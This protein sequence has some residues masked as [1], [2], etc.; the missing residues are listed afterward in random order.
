MSSLLCFAAGLTIAVGMSRAAD[1]VTLQDALARAYDTNPTLQ[2]ARA[3]LRATD[4]QIAQAKS[5]RRPTVDVTGEVGGQVYDSDTQGDGSSVP[6]TVALNLTQPIYRGGSIDAS[7]SQAD[8]VI[9]AQRATLISVEQQVLLRAV[10]AYMD[11]VRDQA[12]LELT[13]NNEEVLTRQLEAT[14]VRFEVGELTRTDV[15]QAESRLAGATAQRIQAEGGLTTSVAV[16]REVIGEDPVDLQPA[17]P[18]A[19]LPGDETETVAASSANPD[20]V[21]AQFLER[22]ARDGTDVV[23]GE[24]LPRV[25]VVGR[26]QAE[27]DISRDGQYD[28]SAQA[29]LQVRIPLYQAG[30]VDS[31]VREA[32]QRVSQR[33]Q[34]VQ[35]QERA[36]TQ[37]ATSAWR[38]L[39]TARAQ[40][41]SFESQVK[42]TEIALQ[43]VREE[44]QVGARTVLDTLDA[45]QEFLDARVSLVR[46]RRDEVVAAHQVLAAVGQLTAANLNLPATPYD[47]ELNYDRVRDKF[48]GTD[49]NGQ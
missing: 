40:I 23:F 5:L 12:V 22:A 43:G 19:S 16:Y 36:A 49:I 31:R 47:V 17:R 9:F 32:K 1:A 39:E 33:R 37:Q 4:E 11:V 8:N 18:P 7:I 3:E 10:S 20:L 29:L 26:L 13:L 14:R 6:G 28:N 21:A 38:A 34:Q 24:L 48:W 45:E 30:G 42:A 35:E 44:A 25:D 15:A 41:V 27:V 2:A 46:A